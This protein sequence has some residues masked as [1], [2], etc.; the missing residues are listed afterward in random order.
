MLDRKGFGRIVGLTATVFAAS[1]CARCDAPA[2]IRGSAP[3]GMA[4]WL[5]SEHLHQGSQAPRVTLLDLIADLGEFVQPR[6]L[7]PD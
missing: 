4:G 7:L 1:L 3:L 6:L 2:Q 5:H